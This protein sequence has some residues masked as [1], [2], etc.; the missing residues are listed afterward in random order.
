L[1]CLIAE[2]SRTMAW[3]FRLPER[4]AETAQFTSEVTVSKPDALG[5][6][7]VECELAEGMM[8]LV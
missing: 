2:S 8:R 3:S 4:F 1:I 7:R 5:L 6:V